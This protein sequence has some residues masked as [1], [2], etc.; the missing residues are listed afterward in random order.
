MM[1]IEAKNAEV[2]CDWEGCKTEGVMDWSEGWSPDGWLFHNGPTYPRTYDLCPEH[3]AP[4]KQRKWVKVRE[5]RWQESWATCLLELQDEFGEH[6]FLE[7]YPNGWFAIFFGGSGSGGELARS[8]DLATL[9][10]RLKDDESI[11]RLF[12]EPIHPARVNL[13]SCV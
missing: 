9:E 3:A 10:A 11:E 4:F 1:W 7:E 8:K 13:R 5:G 6:L 2:T 12:A